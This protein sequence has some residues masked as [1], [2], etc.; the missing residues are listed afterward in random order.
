VKTVLPATA[1]GRGVNRRMKPA[2]MTMPPTGA[3]TSCKRLEHVF[4]FVRGYTFWV[5]LYTSPD[6]NL[7]L[8]PIFRDEFG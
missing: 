5:E 7:G 2:S 1:L 8:T 3:S 6:G 4:N